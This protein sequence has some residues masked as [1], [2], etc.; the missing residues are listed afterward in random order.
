MASRN[1]LLIATSHDALGETGNKTGFWYEELAAPYYVFHDAGFTPVIVSPKG[2]RP[3]VDPRSEAPDFRTPS[4]ERFSADGA[5]QSMLENSVTPEEAPADP[6]AL[7]LVGGHG[8]MWD[9]PDWPGLAQLLHNAQAGGKPIGAVCHGVAGLLCYQTDG[10]H[11]LVADRK[12]T[13]FTNNEEAAVGLTDVVPFLLQDRLTEAGAAFSE[14]AAFSKHV[15]KDGLLV[16][17]Q[18]PSSSQRA[19]EEVLALLAPK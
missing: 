7:F 3:P 2:G 15:A 1:I 19:A 17:G 11:P 16:T 12:L 4:V 18:N 5:A 6:A 14:G 9:F 10:R 13:G 8:T